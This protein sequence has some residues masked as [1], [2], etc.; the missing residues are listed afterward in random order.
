MPETPAVS[1]MVSPD[2]GAMLQGHLA[3]PVF[4]PVCGIPGT[5]PAAPLPAPLPAMAMESLSAD[6]PS[7]QPTQDRRGSS[8]VLLRN[9]PASLCTAACMDVML[10]QAGVDDDLI[11]CDFQA[12]EGGGEA[13]LTFANWE[14]AE[15]CVKHFHGCQ[16]DSAGRPVTA[17]FGPAP[18]MWCDA[19]FPA[20]KAVDKTD[21]ATQQIVPNLGGHVAVGTGSGKVD[22]TFQ[23]V[24]AIAGC[25]ETPMTPSTIAPRSPMVAPS[26]LSH[27]VSWADLCS[28]EEEQEEES[29]SAGTPERSSDDFGIG[30]SGY[31]SD[32]GF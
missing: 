16:W 3:W 7:V 15:Q 1:F 19:G 25:A 31:V 22:A 5:M 9:L 12:G 29:T 10:E 32:D 30:P 24:S 20:C 2:H 14:A 4:I 11:S 13:L 28:D 18:G 26:P 8:P 6:T 21:F 17:E 23:A 27:K